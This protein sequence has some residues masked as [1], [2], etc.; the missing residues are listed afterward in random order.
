[1]NMITE[2][3]SLFSHEMPVHI[4]GLKVKVFTLRYILKDIGLYN[5]FSIA[6]FYQYDKDNIC[7]SLNIPDDVY[8]SKS[9]Y[10]ILF[11]DN[12][13]RFMMCEFLKFILID[14]IV[15]NADFGIIV[16][17]DGCDRVLIDEENITQILE[18]I[19]DVC[20]ISSNKDID[21]SRCINMSAKKMKRSVS[22]KQKKIQELK[23]S[24]VTLK[25]I[26]SGVCNKSNT[27]TYLNVLDHT[28]YQ[29]FDAYAT[30][31]KITNS[32]HVMSGLYS[33]TIDKD[34]IDMEELAW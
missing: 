30:L 6:G 1:M 32:D 28:M 18:D 3:E 13:G 12:S 19:A 24:K 20:G 27:I 10:Q 29:I 5:Y 14:S 22:K 33:G 26:I 4:H 16:D 9:K 25:S 15:I 8:Y 2:L 11:N 17:R 21:Y 34:K 7:E 23:K 31:H